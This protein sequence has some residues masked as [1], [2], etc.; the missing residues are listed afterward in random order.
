[1]TESNSELLRDSVSDSRNQLVFGGLVQDQLSDY[2][3][4]SASK[5][6]PRGEDPGFLD[7]N[8]CPALEETF[9]VTE[10]EALDTVP[11]AARQRIYR[12]ENAPIGVPTDATYA[13]LHSP[14]ELRETWTAG[15]MT[16]RRSLV[17]DESGAIETNLLVTWQGHAFQGITIDRSGAVTEYGFRPENP[18]QLYRVTTHPDGRRVHLYPNNETDEQ[19][20]DPSIAQERIAELRSLIYGKIT[21]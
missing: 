2:Q 18:Q 13:M 19:T 15:R 1:M 7:L 9:T 17:R 16:I 20:I 14:D 4:S 8:N 6:S 10:D 3:Q 12:P 11:D 21:Q 5:N